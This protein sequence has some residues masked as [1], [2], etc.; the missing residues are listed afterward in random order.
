MQPL[1][2][3][4]DED[5]RDETEAPRVGRAS[6]GRGV[7]F[8]AIVLALAAFGI[9]V[10]GIGEAFGAES[11]TLL[12]QTGGVGAFV[13]GAGVVVAGLAIARASRRPSRHEDAAARPRRVGIFVAAVVALV[14]NG[15]FAFV[16]VVAAYFS[17]A[18]FTRGRQ[19]RRRGKVLLPPLVAGRG[20]A[21]WAKR[22]PDAEPLLANDALDPSTRRALAA[23]WRENGRTEL[24]SVG[25]FARLT[26]DLV[27]LG[28][29]PALVVASQRDALDEI[30]HTELCFG[31]A[32]A[33]DGEAIGPGAFPEAAAA[34]TL[35]RTRPLALAELAVDSL[36]DGA[37]HE[38]V[39]ARV[40]AKLARR[41]TDPAIRE[42]LRQIAA[43]EGRHAA[44]GWDVV[45]WC[46]EEGGEGVLRALE[47]ALTVL[48]RTMESSAPPEARDGGF[49]RW[50][51]GS[52]ALEQQEL[53]ATRAMIE[54]RVRALRSLAA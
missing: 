8:V 49:E 6:P 35:S 7:A 40:V 23:R 18:T 25:A 27:A 47:G 29:P 1:Q 5:A 36:V 20:W 21:R 43:D 15:L 16:G 37:L 4:L 31:L 39:S 9:L 38:G 2:V 54:R 50:G 52:A 51:I 3:A 11:E 32:R 44:H 13:G 12:R 30:A 46:V 22:T 19:I 28:A 48:P 10:L 42:V 53:D 41:T 45:V 24:A 34:R 17:T 14:L 33:I 26:L